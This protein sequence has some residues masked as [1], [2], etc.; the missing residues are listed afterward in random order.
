[1]CTLISVVK[2]RMSCNPEND[3]SKGTA[4]LKANESEL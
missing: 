4:I 1:M 2:C 3:L